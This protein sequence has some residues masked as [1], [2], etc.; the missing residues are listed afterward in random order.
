MPDLESYP[1]KLLQR[2]SKQLQPAKPTNQR[3]K[4]RVEE[5]RRVEKEK[6]E[7]EKT[8][9]EEARI[10]AVFQDQLWRQFEALSKG[11]KLSQRA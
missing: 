11:L 9:R 6:M 7:L 2:F 5:S 10:A 4:R 8:V 1:D 3:K